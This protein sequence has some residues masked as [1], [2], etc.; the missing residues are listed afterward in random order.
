MRVFV[1]GIVECAM[2]KMYPMEKD[3]LHLH[4]DNMEALQDPEKAK[5]IEGKTPT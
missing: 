3:R 4:W 1:A 2:E 5:L